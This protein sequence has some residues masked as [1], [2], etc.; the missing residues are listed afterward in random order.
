MNIL[1]IDDSREDRELLIT[2]I[3]QSYSKEKIYTEE[4]EN[5]TIALNKIKEK[6]Y[7]V[8]LLDLFLPESEGLETIKNLMNF[9]K[10]EEKSIPV[11]ILTGLEDYTVGRKAWMLGIK[12]YLIKDEVQSK[13]ISR[14]LTFIDQKTDNK[15]IAV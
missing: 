12:E 14:A 6:D 1:I 10:K 3:N 8:I 15:S 13:D 2:Y 9:L 7:D 5:F 11:V 4:S